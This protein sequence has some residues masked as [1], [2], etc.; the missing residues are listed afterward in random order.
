VIESI[1]YKYISIEGNIGTGKTSL[2]EL[3]LRDTNS[4]LMLEEFAENPFLPYFYENPAKYAFPLELFFMTERYKQ[5]EIQFQAQ[6]LFSDFVLSDYLFIKTL[7]FASI[8]LN[9]SDY[10][11]FYRLYSTLQQSLPSP[12]LIMYLHRSPEELLRQIKKRGRSY[13]QKIQGAYLQ[14]IQDTYFDYFRTLADIPVLIINLDGVD[15]IDDKVQYEEIQRLMR[16]QYQPGMHYISLL[17][18][19]N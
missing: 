13:E 1:P 18:K 10:A 2:C 4:M 7:L 16:R 9:E 14:Q 3:L 12:D 8:N 19:S 6:D 5:Q 15:F 17:T 11:I